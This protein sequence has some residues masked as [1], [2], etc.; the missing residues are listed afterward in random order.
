[1]NASSARL[2]RIVALALPVIAGMWSQNI[3]SL[4]DIYLVS[5][6]GN[7]ALA[8]AGIGA[9]FIFLCQ[10]I[11]LG[12]A[13]GVQVLT[14]RR[15]GAG[16][17][18]GLLSPLNTALLV[19]IVAGPLWSL[20]LYFA[21]P[22]I[23][24]LLHDDPQVI[25]QLV[26]YVQWRVWAITFV[27]MNYAF[28]GYWTAIDRSGVYLRTLLL[29]HGGNIVLNAI[30]IY[31]LAGFPALG[32]T[33]AGIGTFCATALGTV[34]Y[35]SLT[36]RQARNS[37]FL[38]RYLP[39][40]EARQLAA[41]AVPYGVQQVFFAAGLTALLWIIGFLGTDELAAAHVVITIT[42]VAFLP[43]VA[44]GIAAATLVG[45]AYGRGD[46]EDARAWA[47]EV[48]RLAVLMLGVI[49]MPMWIMPETLLGVFLHTPETVA[50]ARTPLQIVGLILFVDGIGVVLMHALHGVGYM[51]QATR[52]AI[53]LQWLGFLPVAYIVGPLLGGGLVTIWLAHAGY[54]IAQAGVFAAMWQG[55]AWQR[56]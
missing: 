10:A 48:V 8:A 7:A 41:L 1:M 6:L 26:P 21:A 3:M 53:G 18:T 39:G 32:L 17:S 54:R 51:R 33:G 11:T 22:K 16:D 45:Q 42:L 50:L 25:A 9:F 49:G 24:P 20:A 5:G 4:V 30:L 44:M 12:A 15:Y 2:R 40:G 52:I 56:S 55:R 14:A 23:L 31:G 37:G 34:I 43:S 46:L 27:G 19:L 47:W 38:H 36:W 35:A 29:M 13:A 28:R